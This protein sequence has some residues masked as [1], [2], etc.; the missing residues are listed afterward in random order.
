MGS[1]SYRVKEIEREN[2]QSAV[3]MCKRERDFVNVYKKWSEREGVMSSLSRIKLPNVYKSC[4]K[5]ISLEKL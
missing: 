1:K 2:M 4:P 3:D 5:M